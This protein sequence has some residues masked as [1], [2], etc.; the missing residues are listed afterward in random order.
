MQR[1]IEEL[2][3]DEEADKPLPSEEQARLDAYYTALE[4][5]EN[6]I[7]TPDR[8]KQSEESAQRT[9]Y[10]ARLEA[11]LEQKKNSLQQLEKLIQEI[12]ALKREEVQ[13]RAAVH[14]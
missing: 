8:L 4:A 11:L 3:A 12:E 9:N 2:R 13:L 6:V 1:S 10:L 5:A 14:S 7:L